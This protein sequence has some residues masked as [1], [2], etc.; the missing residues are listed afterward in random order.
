MKAIMVGGD[1]YDNDDIYIWNFDDDLKRQFFQFFFTRILLF[2]LLG[3]Q[4]DVDNL[5][6]ITRYW[7]NGLWEPCQDFAPNNK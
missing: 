3:I 7:V 1:N 5:P 4:L 2:L 6:K